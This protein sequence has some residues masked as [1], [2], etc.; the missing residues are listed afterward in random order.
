VDDDGSHRTSAM[1]GLAD[2]VGA[3]DG[4]LMVEPTRLRAE[5]PCA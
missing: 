4:Q 3:L 5:L 2:R 1:V